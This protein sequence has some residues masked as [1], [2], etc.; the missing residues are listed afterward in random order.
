MTGDTLTAHELA[1]VEVIAVRVVELLR[2]GASSSSRGD[3]GLVDAQT[4]ALALGISRQ[5]VYSQ[6]ER[7]GG[8]RI[9]DGPR[10]RWR[11]DLETAR[12]AGVRLAGRQLSSEN[13][14]ADAA[15]EGKRGRRRRRMPNGLPPAGSILA[16]RP[17]DGAR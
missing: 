1:L 14:S 15:S 7:L 6:A 8:R 11:F 10:A 9:G 5:T 4:V 3:V 2:E 12:T 16:S 17:L 13:A